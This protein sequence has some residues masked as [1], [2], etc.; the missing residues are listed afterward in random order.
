MKWYNEEAKRKCKELIDTNRGCEIKYA[1][2]EAPIAKNKIK[3]KNISA[4]VREIDA[5]RNELEAIKEKPKINAI[6]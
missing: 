4:L 6:G 3:D 1:G 5:K 2:I